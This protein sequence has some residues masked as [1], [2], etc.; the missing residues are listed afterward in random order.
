VVA[1]VDLGV[2]LEAPGEA[3]FAVDASVVVGLVALRVV[4][5]GSFVVGETSGVLV[6][7]I[8]MLDCG[9]ST[10]G[11]EAGSVIVSIEGGT[12]VPEMSGTSPMTSLVGSFSV[13]VCG[14]SNPNSPLVGDAYVTMAA[15][16]VASGTVASAIVS[17][18]VPAARSEICAFS[19]GVQGL[20]LT[21]RPTEETA[22]QP[23]VEATA[24]PLTQVKR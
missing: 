5:T 21:L 18:A 10:V 14:S 7:R 2:V 12:L 23:K 24:T 16:A 15:G 3:V 11:S 6:V 1:G 8:R 17:S 13:S 9:M 4:G 19:A 20:S 22:N